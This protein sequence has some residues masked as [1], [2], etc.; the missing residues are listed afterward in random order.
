MG[1]WLFLLEHA[2]RGVSHAEANIKPVEHQETH[3]LKLL[4]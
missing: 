1:H 4:V 2:G 3:D